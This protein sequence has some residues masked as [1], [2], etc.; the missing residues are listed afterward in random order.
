MIGD[1]EQWDS[2]LTAH[3]WAVLTTL[4]QSGS[5]VNSIV[6]YARRDDVL[7]VST[8]GMTFKR[9]MLEQDC[10]VSLC[11]FNNAEPFNFVSIE[12][13][14]HILTD[15]LEEDTMRVFDNISGTGYQAPEDLAGWLEAQQR[16]IL[17]IHPERVYGVIR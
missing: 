11:A 15:D 1:N 8:P 2:F 10:R 4:R 9:K 5:P 3:R 12:G 7:V 6:A 13:V 17:E 16:V 14:A